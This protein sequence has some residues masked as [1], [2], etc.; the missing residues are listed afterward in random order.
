MNKK[1]AA[2]GSSHTN[3]SQAGR[4]E[5]E[6]ALVNKVDRAVDSWSEKLNVLIPAKM[7]RSWRTV[8]RGPIILLVP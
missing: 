1:K 5:A 3:P 4:K 8:A 6:M 7:P 2:N